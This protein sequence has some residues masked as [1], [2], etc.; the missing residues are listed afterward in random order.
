MSAQPEKE[1]Q[2]PRRWLDAPRPLKERRRN[3]NHRTVGLRRGDELEDLENLGT[4][5]DAH[6]EGASR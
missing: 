3:A 6:A 5:P 1:G 2:P 4:P